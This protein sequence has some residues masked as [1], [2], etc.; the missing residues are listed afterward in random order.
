MPLKDMVRPATN[1]EGQSV[2][3][4]DD[5]TPKP[6][7]PWGLEITLENDELE[8]LGNPTFAIGQKVSIVAVASVQ[9]LNEEKLHGA[10]V[11][12][13]VTLQIEQMDVAGPEATAEQRL[14]KD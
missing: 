6:L 1:G 9:N 13:R 11:S 5:E 2:L 8:K 3:A 12:R 7:Y 10:Q 14:Y 4:S